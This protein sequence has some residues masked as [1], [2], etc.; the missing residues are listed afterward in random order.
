MKRGGNPQNLTPFKKGQ[1]GNPNGRQKKLPALD[2]LLAD[3]LGGENP[4]E[5]E[6]KN[7]LEALLKQAKKGNVQA[8]VAVLDRAYGKPKQPVEHSGDKDN[9][10]KVQV[11]SLTDEQLKALTEIRDKGIK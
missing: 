1:S 5:S 7:V 11:D 9:P 8:A 2:A 6:A 4:D 10:V 3:V